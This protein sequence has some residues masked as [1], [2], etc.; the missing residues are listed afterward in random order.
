MKRNSVKPCRKYLQLMMV[1]FVL[2]L[3][4]EFAL[5]ADI[6]G[7]WLFSVQMPDGD[8]HPTFVLKQEGEKVS[9]TYSGPLGP[10]KVSGKVNGEAAVFNFEGKNNQGE[11]VAASYSVRIESTTRMTGTVDFGK[12]TLFQCTAVKK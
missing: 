9:G 8:S 12:G 7:T 5:A 11:P 6:S 3:G 1:L 2:L 10:A 4:A